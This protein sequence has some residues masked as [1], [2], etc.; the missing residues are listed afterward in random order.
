MIGSIVDGY[1]GIGRPLAID[2]TDMVGLTTRTA[3]EVVLALAQQLQFSSSSRIMSQTLGAKHSLFLGFIGRTNALSSFIELPLYWFGVP[4]APT[5]DSRARVVMSK[6]QTVHGTLVCHDPDSGP[7]SPIDV[8]PSPVTFTVLDGVTSVTLGKPIVSSGIDGWQYLVPWTWAVGAG[9]TDATG[10]TFGIQAANAASAG[11]AAKT[12]ITIAITGNDSATLTFVN[13]APMGLLA[14][15]TSGA[16]RVDL[17]QQMRVVD[18]QGATVTSDQLQF[19]LAGT[20]PPGTAIDPQTGTL[21]I[22][23]IEKTVAPTAEYRF[24][25]LVNSIS[26]TATANGILPVVLMIGAT[27]SGSN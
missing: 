20:P 16:W 27:P 17:D 24:A 14:T 5:W 21:Q 18:G 19:A 9:T 4:D 22:H 1:D 6:V 15:G 2:F 7:G 11:T 26:T 23:F 12:T 3:T 13:D 8:D 25:V 10:G